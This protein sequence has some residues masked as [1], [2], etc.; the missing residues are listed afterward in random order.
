MEHRVFRVREL[1]DSI[2]EYTDPSMLIQM[3]HVC[4]R[5][6]T[7]ALYMINNRYASVR[8]KFS[9][10]GR[11]THFEEPILVE[12]GRYTYMYFGL[13]ERVVND[14]LVEFWVPTPEQLADFVSRLS[15]S[16]DGIIRRLRSFSTPLL[17]TRKCKTFRMTLFK[18]SDT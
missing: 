8:S 2:V 9:D 14:E 4:S 7:K 11:P 15:F 16:R 18:P 5:R 17:A 3:L 10:E 13:E 6:H 12:Y 1:W